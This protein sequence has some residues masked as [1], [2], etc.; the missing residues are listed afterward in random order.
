M[1]V[2]LV[3]TGLL[4]NAF[5]DRMK[6]IFLFEWHSRGQRFD[7]AYLHQQRRMKFYTSSALTF[8]FK[9]SILKAEKGVAARR[10]AQ[11]L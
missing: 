4:R 3:A 5:L 9:C 2:A 8:V 10:L 11:K 7:P 1:L 6:W